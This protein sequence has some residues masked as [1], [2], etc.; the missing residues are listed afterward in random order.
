MAS[1]DG[2][3]PRRQEEEGQPRG[4]DVL[5]AGGVVHGWLEGEERRRQEGHASATGDLKG[6][7]ETQQGG[8][9][10]ADSRG[11]K[12]LVPRRSERSQSPRERGRQGPVVDIGEVRAGD[13]LDQ[14]PAVVVVIEDHVGRDGQRDGQHGQEDG[15]T[16]GDRW[17]DDGGGTPDE[18]DEP[19]EAP[20]AEQQ[21]RAKQRQ[22]VLGRQPI[23][24][25]PPRRRRL[26]RTRPRLGGP[27]PP[28]ALPNPRECGGLGRG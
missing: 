25:R 3:E 9:E 6:P 20:R 2:D 11:G 28:P 8:E 23:A 7:Q 16:P 14:V 26:R 10:R 19:N 12:R 27:T 1:G 13:Q 22:Q 5:R 4:H 17:L 18:P 24:R 15:Q 21:G